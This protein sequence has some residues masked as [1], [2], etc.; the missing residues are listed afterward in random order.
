MATPQAAL[1]KGVVHP[2][3]GPE[4]RKAQR[5]S[6]AAPQNFAP[7]SLGGLTVNHPLRRACILI[8][9][10]RYTSRAT[11]LTVLVN[12]IVMGCL[13]YSD[14]WANGSAPTNGPTLP[15]NQFV[16]K[17]E[18]LTLVYFIV[19]LV[20]KVVAYGMTGPKGYWRNP[21]NKLD[22]F[23]VASGVVSLLYSEAKTTAT[24]IRF[25]RVLR[26]LRTVHSVPGLK[27]LVNALLA[28]LPA[29]LNISILLAF[30]YIV[31][32]II[33][34]QIWCGEYHYRCRLTPYPIALPFE[35]RATESL[36]QYQ[37]ATFLSLALAN[38]AVYRCPRIDVE[39]N[40]WTSRQPCFWPLDPDDGQYCGSRVCAPGRY[41]GSNYD[42]RGNP[43]FMDLYAPDGS[44][45][46]DIMT[47]PDFTGDLNFGLAGFDSIGGSLVI[48]FQV[49]TASGWMQITQNTQDAYSY[50]TAGVYFNIVLFLGMCFLLQIN[51]AI[52]VSAFEK[53]CD[54]Q[55]A[56]LSDT[57]TTH[58][59]R[60]YSLRRRVWQTL[61]PLQHRVIESLQ[62]PLMQQL[63]AR[64]KQLYAQR[65]FK[66]LNTGATFVNVAALACTHHDMSY[67]FAY[68]L[69]IIEFICLLW[70][71]ID[72][73]LRLIAFGP[74]A[75]FSHPLNQFDCASIFVGAVDYIMY[76]PAFVD[77]TISPPSPFTALRALRVVRL[78]Q[79]WGPL[80]HLL[81]A[82]TNAMGEI[83]HFLIFLALFVY[84]FALMGMDLFA[85]KF[86]F[87]A[88]NRPISYANA[89][90]TVTLH[91]S[92]FDT[93]PTALFTV[94]QVLTYDDWPAVMYDG[95][96][97]AGFVAPLYFISIVVL[98]VWIVMNMFTAI[99][100]SCVMNQVDRPS[101]PDDQTV[102]VIVP[103]ASL[104]RVTQRH[105]M[106][107]RYVQRSIRRLEPEL[108]R[109]NLHHIALPVRFPFRYTCL[110][111]VGSAWFETA[112]GLVIACAVVTTALDSPLLDATE[113]LGLMICIANRVYAVLF[114]LEMAVTLLAIGCH[115]YVRDPWKVLDGVIVLT[116]I[117]AWSPG[118]DN[119]NLG[120][121]RALR[122]LRALRPLRVINQLPQ[123]KVVVNT[124]FR[125][126]PE[127]AKSLVFFVYMLFIFGIAGVLFFKGAMNSCSISPYLYLDNPAYSPPPPWFPRGY[128]GNYSMADLHQ[129]DVMTFP[130]SLAAMDP[131][132]RAVVAPL[133]LT[134][135]KFATATYVPTSKE[136]CNCFAANG[137]KW[138]AKVPQNFDNILRAMGSLYELTTFEGWTAVA[139]ASVDASGDDKQPI[140]GQHPFYAVFWVV[141]MIVG[142]FF[143][144]NLFLG[145]L[146]DSFIREKYGGFVT[147]EQINWINLQRK[148]VALSPVVQH[149]R[150]TGF[151]RGLCHRLVS[152]RWFEHV[153]TLCILLNTAFMTITYFG[154]P[155]VLGVMI[156]NINNAFAVL[157]FGEMAA[158][159]AAIG[160]AAYFAQGWNQFDFVIVC[161]SVASIVLPYLTT[162]SKAS[163]GLATVLRVFRAGRALRMINKAKLMRSLFDTI[164]VSLPA[165][166][167]VTALLMLLYYIFAAVGV[168]LFAKVGYGPSMVNSHQN[169]QSFWLAFQTLI[170]FSTGENWD[171]Y[172]WELYAISP[173]SNPTCSDPIFD[174]SM[175]GFNDAPGCVPLNGC[176]SWLVVPFFYTFTMVVGYIGLNL[177]S[178]ILVDAVAD[179]D[180]T[181]ASAVEDLPELVRLWAEHD[182]AGLGVISVGALCHILKRL[183]P[184]LGFGG[185]PGYTGDRL[186][187][188]LAL[189]DIPVYDSKFVHF[190]DVPR[191]L[192]IRSM[193]DGDP[194]RYTQIS[195]LMDQMG[196]TRAFHDHWAKR[197]KS[198]HDIIEH[199]VEV[200]PVHQYM[201]TQIIL[202]WFVQKA[203]ALRLAKAR[204]ALRSDIRRLVYAIVDDVVPP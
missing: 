45:V 161:T 53:A 180:A 98:G 14:P 76:Q 80:Q 117:L 177:F 25:L 28:A 69:E 160:T 190:R 149:P 126:I 102:R 20:L 198:M 101:M 16:E 135:C 199:S 133:W 18:L 111:I 87:D 31:F 202:R 194:L 155:Q 184:P 66:T 164:T 186:Q 114:A 90:P 169:F 79:S 71:A 34:V 176:G 200:T 44:L 8:V 5:L 38:P 33:G 32:A 166:A 171:N 125:C 132:T 156:D 178:G 120:G 179:A 130:K 153:M 150:P 108:Q 43:R 143:M 19:E 47:E 15:I 94:F 113:G 3:H 58:Q 7:K 110:Q 62:T 107:M 17:I 173:P 36:E 140:P 82:M 49:V 188:V 137:T 144:P 189:L 185:L 72:L 73:F 10:H 116:S 91:R 22:F 141:F 27:V 172:L 12:S 152:F 81:L 154:E 11:L 26:P 136:V 6:K 196:I 103:D 203:G 148:L 139:L 158:K 37:N 104:A 92:N 124:L 204:E 167:N 118:N 21:W 88:A 24:G 78:A 115:E 70:F 123:L 162:R 60:R 23:I 106:Q 174:S 89:V 127:I 50:V 56:L 182:P 83:A 29:Q 112:T 59:S 93:M 146:C 2:V 77:G 147:D 68:N 170:G 65:W 95:W 105:L 151:V 122:T 55:A 100:V 121:I 46:F 165:V 13:D 67:N 197:F 193:S 84:I 159:M 51:M 86:N 35:P 42:I 48:I 1:A 57:S 142:A 85:T 201:A 74:M 192:V 183:P 128:S 145:V 9:T 41:C 75:Y 63:R 175:C 96:I 129:F 4:P 163:M 191:A 40:N 64:L 119:A 30:S 187:R 195:S 181:T 157:F 97:S 39:S 109:A 138:E 54:A 168:Q 99:T 61:V 131:L 134:T 52:M